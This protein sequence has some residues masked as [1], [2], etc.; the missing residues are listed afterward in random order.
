MCGW[1]E[2]TST[3]KRARLKLGSRSWGFRSWSRFLCSWSGSGVSAAGAARGGARR[4]LGL[5]GAAAPAPFQ[6]PCPGAEAVGPSRKASV[7]PPAV[8]RAKH[9]AGGERTGLQPPQLPLWG[10]VVPQGPAGC[11]GKK[12]G[13]ERLLF[14]GGLRWRRGTGAAQLGRGVTSP[15]SCRFS[16]LSLRGRVYIVEALDAEISPPPRI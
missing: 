3:T 14:R 12:A 15:L 11:R 13:C 6:A 10:L 9:G 7:F 1:A 4:A 2:C 5:S 8:L 16:L